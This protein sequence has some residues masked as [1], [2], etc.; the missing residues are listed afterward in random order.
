[1]TTT[2]VL[3]DTCYNMHWF[4]V[5]VAQ[6]TINRNKHAVISMETLLY[7]LIFTNCKCSYQSHHLQN[8]SHS[9]H[10]MHHH[11]PI[12]LHC[13]PIPH[14]QNHHHHYYQMQFQNLNRNYQH[15]LQT[16]R[17]LQWNPALLGFSTSKP[18]YNELWVVCYV[19]KHFNKPPSS[20]FSE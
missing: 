10:W 6:C 3:F 15:H 8:H 7:K 20:Q 18:I 17:D 19:L 2:T 14:F 11:F 12:I 4:G 16:H 13:L 1:M 5:P 9:P